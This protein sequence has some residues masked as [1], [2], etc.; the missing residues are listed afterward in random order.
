MITK[1]FPACVIQ[2]SHTS[3]HRTHTTLPKPT[4]TSSAVVEVD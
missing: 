1:L 4:L 2:N 3:N